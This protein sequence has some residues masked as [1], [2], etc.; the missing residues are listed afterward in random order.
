MRRSGSDSQLYHNIMNSLGVMMIFFFFFFFAGGWL[1]FY[2]P[3]PLNR[4]RS[5]S[6][7][8]SDSV[9]DLAESGGDKRQALRRQFGKSLLNDNRYNRGGK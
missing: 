7:L 8:K 5:E 9:I 6:E 4:K 2:P 1:I 3:A